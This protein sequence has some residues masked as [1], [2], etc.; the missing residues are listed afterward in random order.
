MTQKK[1]L[2]A[3][4]A[5]P[6]LLERMLLLAEDSPP[7]SCTSPEELYKAVAPH[8]L[9]Y[10]E[11]RLAVVA[12]NRRRKVLGVEVLTKGN[13]SF[14]IV[15]PRQIF[16]WA[17]LQG[18]SGASAIALAHNHP[19]GDPSPSTQDVEVTRRVLRT[20]RVLGVSLLDH[21]ILAGSGYT[22]LRERED[23][24]WGE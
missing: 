17:L 23:I 13:D 2:Q 3:V 1:L 20:G 8:L 16:R 14:T 4:R 10:P 22:S 24:G 12:L 5:K 21:L 15:C 18:R 9:G 11:E 7:Y 6:E 19:S